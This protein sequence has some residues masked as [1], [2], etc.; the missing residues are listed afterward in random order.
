MYTGEPLCGSSPASSYEPSVAK[1]SLSTQWPGTR[2]SCQYASSKSGRAKES[3]WAV[4][5]GESRK[6]Q[7]PCSEIRVGVGPGVPRAR[8]QTTAAR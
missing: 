4:A 8:R 6:R 5:V 7:V 1:L 2:R 3:S